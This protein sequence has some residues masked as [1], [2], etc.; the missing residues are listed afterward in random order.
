MPGGRQLAV[1]ASSARRA[2]SARFLSAYAGVSWG[3]RGGP[4]AR[5]APPARGD[6]PVGAPP[7]GGA[8]VPRA[9]AVAAPPPRPT[10]T[11][12]HTPVKSGSLASADQSADVGGFVLNSCAWTTVHDAAT[13]IAATST[14]PTNLFLVLIGSC[15]L[16]KPSL[17]SV[18]T[19]QEQRAAVGSA[20]RDLNGRETGRDA[21]L[22]RPDVGV[23][24]KTCAPAHAGP[25]EGG[26]HEYELPGRRGAFR[27]PGMRGSARLSADT[28]VW[29]LQPR[30]APG[31]TSIQVSARR[32]DGRTLLLV[33]RY[34]G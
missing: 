10:V 27:R 13:A 23:R 16:E 15:V 21:R 22:Q 9:G 7:A 19:D 5:P 33:S 8:P 30:M 20:R 1:S 31:L 12:S 2:S 11:A 28:D 4:P 18:A 32:P 6:A 25:P 17:P 24:G 34:R 26:P 14:A 29:A 3:P